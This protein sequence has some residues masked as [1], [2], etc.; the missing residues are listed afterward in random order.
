MRRRKVASSLP[1]IHGTEMTLRVE[2]FVPTPVEARKL[3]HGFVVTTP[4]NPIA[5]SRNQSHR[6]IK[7]SHRYIEK[8]I[9]SLHRGISPLQG[10]IPSS[11]HGR[12]S[13]SWNG[14]V[15]V[16]SLFLRSVELEQ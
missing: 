10:G 13:V 15:M 4:R 14:T 9:S 2:K 3:Q 5:T 8:I 12:T 6:Y 1:R 7:D 16:H 11:H